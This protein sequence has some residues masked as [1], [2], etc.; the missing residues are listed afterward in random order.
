MNLVFILR[1]FIFDSGRAGEEVNDRKRR[2]GS[3]VPTM[4]QAVPLPRRHE[5]AKHQN[6]TRLL[7]CVFSSTLRDDSSSKSSSCSITD[8][9]AQEKNCKLNLLFLKIIF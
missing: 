6:Q 3:E 9:E 7:L 1:K 4:P 8:L 5:E 2:E